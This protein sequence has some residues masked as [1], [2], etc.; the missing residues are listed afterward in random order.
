MNDHWSENYWDNYIR[1]KFSKSSKSNKNLTIKELYKVYD[2]PKNIFCG[3]TTDDYIVKVSYWLEDNNIF[4]GVGYD[5]TYYGADDLTTYQLYLKDINDEIVV[6][7][8]KEEFK[9]NIINYF[10]FCE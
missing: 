3:H 6:D 8:L 4:L 9:W 2:Y 10:S 7:I 1:K 5:E